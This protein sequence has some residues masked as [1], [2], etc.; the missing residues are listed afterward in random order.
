ME[1]ENFN[2]VSNLGGCLLDSSQDNINS[3]NNV[4][5]ILMSNAKNV[6][7]VRKISW[8]RRARELPQN[9]SIE[10]FVLTREI[11]KRD[12]SQVLRGSLHLHG[13]KKPKYQDNS[14]ESNSTMSKVVAA[15]IEECIKHLKTIVTDDMN[16]LL[17]KKIIAFEVESAISQ[18][19][20]LSSPGLDGFSTTF[21]QYHWNV[22][23]SGVC[24]AN[25]EG[26]QSELWPS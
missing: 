17:T 20:A 8:K 16:A 23:R 22:V 13:T 14:D 18:M 11:K 3:S 4:P 5:P 9:R 19:N 1:Y 15:K 26:F 25:Q 21:Y 24:F 7:L 10:P 6:L 2:V 12:S